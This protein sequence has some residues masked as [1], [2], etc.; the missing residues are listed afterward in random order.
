MSGKVGIGVLCVQ[1]SHDNKYLASGTSKG[2]IEFYNIQS[3]KS[4]VIMNNGLSTIPITCI[5]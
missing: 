4:R 3:D 1:Y 5:K 2:T